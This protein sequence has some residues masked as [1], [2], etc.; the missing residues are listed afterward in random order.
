MTRV[1]LCCGLLHLLGT[2][3]PADS[4][5][6]PSVLDPRTPAEAWNVIRLSNVNVDRLLE[7]KRT[8]EIPVQVSFMNTALRSLAQSGAAPEAITKS[9][10]A[11]SRAAELNKAVSTRN[12]TAIRS[13]VEA[14]RAIVSELESL[15]DPRIV[16]AE[17][18]LC[19]M[20]PDVISDSDNSNRGCTKC[21]MTLIPRRIPWSLTY[22]TP[23][24]P[25]MKLEAVANAP[26][27]AGRK[28]VVKIKL[29]HGDGAPVL[30]SDL[31]LMHSQRIH[32]LIQDP[33]LG[34]Y[35][36]E[37]PVG[38]GVPGEY[39]FSFTPQRSAPYRVWA[40]IVPVATGVQELPKADLPSAGKGATAGPTETKLM[41]TSGGLTF[42]LNLGGSAETLPRAQQHCGMVVTIT[43]PEGQPVKQ[44]EPLMNAFAHLVGFY[45]DFETVV[46]LH[47]GG[48]DVLRDDVRGGPALFFNFF[49]PKPGLLRLYCQVQVK[50]ES[51]FAAFNV[52]VHP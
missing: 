15:F 32:L 19:P 44:L 52:N 51:I 27:E 36:H 35:H 39:E 45:D 30:P 3:S 5:V 41:T 29:R 49:P 8:S 21:G 1:I 4:P 38:T 6:A 34:D 11:I 31:L 24:K 40:D 22:M 18:Y 9:N 16:K 28:T 10:S 42:Q 46:H 43:D 50:G 2:A 20:H 26:I 7:E 47:P 14:L 13:S 33:S 23:G 25:S 37:H 17:I 48:G 12:E